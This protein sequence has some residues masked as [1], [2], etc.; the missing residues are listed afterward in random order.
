MSLRPIIFGLLGTAI[1]LSF[2]FAI[3]TVISGWNFAWFQFIKNWYWIVSLTVGFGAQ[4]G[5]F[6]YARAKHR[7]DVSG[8]VAAV[9]GGA[10]G[11]AMVS[12][13]AHYLVN[14]LPIVGVS[15]FAALIGQYQTE[16]FV[17][18]LISNLLGIGY[19]FNKSQLLQIKFN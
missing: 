19:M 1:L 2:Y 13:C 17:V 8:K 16:L 9:S 4:V 11:T 12:C 3:L 18:G 7:A 10:S 5:L 15:G 14:I 6:V